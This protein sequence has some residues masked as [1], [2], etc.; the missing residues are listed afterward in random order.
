VSILELGST[1]IANPVDRRT[2][3]LESSALLQQMRL[4]PM[5]TGSA[6]S[7]RYRQ[8]PRAVMRP[9]S[10][11]VVADAHS[12]GRASTLLLFP[13]APRQNNSQCGT[14]RFYV[15]CT[16]I[17]GRDGPAR[18]DQGW[19]PH[20]SGIIAPQAHPDSGRA[21]RCQYQTRPAGAKVDRHLAAR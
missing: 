17:G 16:I 15:S 20:T 21:F 4:S 7:A 11:L 9:R 12:G 5:R 6:R 10:S 13:M 14:S 3:S 1:M 18:D 19:S 2:V 8:P